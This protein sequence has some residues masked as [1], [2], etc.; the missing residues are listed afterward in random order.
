MQKTIWY[1]YN[2]TCTYTHTYVRTHTHTYS[3]IHSYPRYTG[4]TST[5]CCKQ[6]KKLSDFYFY[7]YVHTHICTQTHT[8]HINTHIHAYI[9]IVR[10]TGV[11]STMYCKQCKKLSTPS[12]PTPSRLWLRCVIVS[13]TVSFNHHELYYPIIINSICLRT[14]ARHPRAYDSGVLL[15]HELYYLIITNSMIQ[16]SWTLSIYVLQPATLAPMTQ[17]CHCVTKSMIWCPRT[18]SCNHHELHVSTHPS[19]TPSLVW[20][21]FVSMSRTLWSDVHELYHLIITNFMYLRTLA[22]HP[23]S[24]DSGVYE[25]C[26]SL[27]HE[28]PHQI[29]TNSII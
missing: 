24:Y 18:V 6:C 5:L 1:V 9:H 2:C 26:V 28:L 25:S 23:R 14:P 20:L 16:L 11:T 15:C 10:K 3:H 17:V 13:R 21:G 29:I 22:R 4:V 19:P 12:S 7:I 27:Y 8:T